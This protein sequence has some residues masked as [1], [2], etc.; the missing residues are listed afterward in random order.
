MESYRI[1]N[2]GDT[3]LGLA[4]STQTLGVRSASSTVALHKESKKVRLVLIILCILLLLACIALAVLLILGIPEK[5]ESKKDGVTCKEKKEVIHCS[6][7]ACLEVA[8][9]LKQEMN[10]SVDP[11]KDFFE[12]SCGSWIKNNPIPPSSNSFSTFAKLSKQNN[13]KLL[14]LLLE[15]DDLP[16]GHAVRKAK[17]YFKSCMNEGDNDTTAKLEITRLINR[18]GSWPLGNA[19]WNASTWNPFAVLVKFQ[20]G[21]LS[22]TWPLFDVGTSTDPYNSSRSILKV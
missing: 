11:C 13:E 10:E 4:T 5:D 1:K 19:S 8:G 3:E 7:E 17:D 2:G 16:N 14:L 9:E 20:R 18:F 12:Y 21:V 22:G 15:D 6:S